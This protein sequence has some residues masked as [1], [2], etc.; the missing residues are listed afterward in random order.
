MDFNDSFF[1]PLA[2]KIYIF[3]STQKPGILNFPSFQEQSM[4]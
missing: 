2:T 4:K 3:F 1:S